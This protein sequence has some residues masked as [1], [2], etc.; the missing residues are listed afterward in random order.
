MDQTQ[1]SYTNLI[2]DLLETHPKTEYG[3]FESYANAMYCKDCQMMLQPKYVSQIPCKVPEFIVQQDGTVTYVHAKCEKLDLT[4]YIHSIASES[5]SWEKTYW[6]VWSECHFLSCITCKF[7]YPVRNSAMCQYHPESPE[8]FPI[9]N[10]G[11]EQ[12]IGRYPCCGERAFRFELV[13]NPF[14]CKFRMH[15]PNKENIF[16]ERIVKLMCSN[17]EFTVANPPALN[18]E[19]KFMKFVNLDPGIKRQNYQH[20]WVKLTLGANDYTHQPIISLGSNFPNCQK[21]KKNW[22]DLNKRRTKHFGELKKWTNN[23]DK[24]TTANSK[25]SLNLKENV[26]ISS[27]MSCE[28]LTSTKNLTSQ[29]SFWKTQSPMTSI[30]DSQREQESLFFDQITVSL[31]KSRKGENGLPGTPDQPCRDSY[32]LIRANMLAK[33]EANNKSLIMRCTKPYLDKKKK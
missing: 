21:K 18:R 12:P 1:L 26:E 11:L 24:P 15:I 27:Q 16:C 28:K 6:Q 31:V 9:G 13:K 23:N 29:G 33:I 30:Q 22:K 3:H 19:H 4:K 32:T 7:Y 10:L 17:L 8:Y 20:W 5:G 2:N 25:S 14:G